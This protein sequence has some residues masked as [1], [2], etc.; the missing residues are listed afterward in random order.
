MRRNALIHSVILLV[1]ITLASESSTWA[2]GPPSG[3]Q[4]PRFPKLAAV[5]R[6]VKSAATKARVAVQDA[7][8]AMAERRALK[9]AANPR[10]VWVGHVPMGRVSSAKTRVYYVDGD[11]VAVAAP[12]PQ[13]VPR[14][15][16]VH[17][18]D[19]D[20]IVQ[21]GAR[22]VGSVHIGG[23]GDV[24]AGDKVEGDS[25]AGDVRHQFGAHDNAGSSSAG[26]PASPRPSASRPG[27]RQVNDGDFVAG[28]IFNS[29][30]SGHVSK[31]EHPDGSSTVSFGSSGG[32][33]RVNGR[34]FSN[35]RTVFRR[36]GGPSTVT[37]TDGTRVDVPKS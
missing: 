35:V 12:A 28:D 7:R 13:T 5:V 8:A 1:G 30:G 31:V 20:V 36:P 34:E 27:G 2:A 15:G 18:T 17:V 16:R 26:R 3:A 25:Y 6:N 32:T 9:W 19:G 22:S 11:G 24:Y 4:P 29:H 37:H 33:A 14:S 23:T 10:G 21:H